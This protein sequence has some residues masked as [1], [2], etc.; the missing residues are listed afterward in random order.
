VINW[1]ISIWAVLSI[2]L[3]AFSLFTAWTRR[4]VPW[5]KGTSI[6]GAVAV[7]AISIVLVGSALGHA[8]V[9]WKGVT[10][11]ATGKVEILGFKMVYEEAVFLMLDVPG[12]PMLFRL[13][14][15]D[16][17]AERLQEL[18]NDPNNEKMF[19]NLD[20]G[21]S[22]PGGGGAEDDALGIEGWK[23][24]NESLP[25]KNGEDGGVD[26]EVGG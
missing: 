4:D 24:D 9:I 21:E 3:L 23:Y 17:L 14:W 16:D 20:G 7:A 26:L 11:P 19:L 15:S 25:P 12:E 2:V 10:I 6:I 8:T 22:T 5:I 1:L 13:E 18:F